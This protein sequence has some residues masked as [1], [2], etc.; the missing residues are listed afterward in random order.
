MAGQD[1]VTL[2]E[3]ASRLEVP[4]AGDN[5]NF[6]RDAVFEGSLELGGVSRS[7]WGTLIDSGIATAGGAST[8][9]D[10]GAD[11][12]STALVG[13]AL[14]ITGGTGAGQVRDIDSHTGTVITTT[15]AWTTQ[16]D[17][18]STYEIYGTGNQT[19]DQVIAASGAGDAAIKQNLL[20]A[21]LA[22][23]LSNADDLYDPDTNAIPVVGNSLCLTPDFAADTDWTKGA[24]WTIAAGVASA[25]AAVTAL[26]Q[27]V[28]VIKDQTYEITFTI[29]NYV[30]GGV[31]AYAEGAVLGV[32]RAANGTF[33]VMFVAAATGAVAFGVFGSTAATLDVDDVILT[34]VTPGR[35]AADTLAMDGWAKTATADIFREHSGASTKDGSFYALKMVSGAVDDIVSWPQTVNEAVHIAKFAGKTVT[36]GVWA[37][38]STANHARLQM[39]DGISDFFSSYHTGGGAYEWLEVTAP[40]ASAASAFS[41]RLRGDVNAATAYFSQPMLAFGSSIGEGNYVPPTNRWVTV[42]AT[43][44]RIVNANLLAADDKT[45]SLEV[46][47]NG[48]LPK[49]AKTLSVRLAGQNSAVANGQG[50]RIGRESASSN[51]LICNPVVNNMEQSVNGE[52]RVASDGTIYQLV[53]TAG[54]TLSNCVCDVHKVEI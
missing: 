38:T 47:S 8:L 20:P 29:S 44:I 39:N 33:S 1:V 31:K 16:P 36:F 28:S 41:A 3:V 40:I 34:V 13:S 43:S 12:G 26:E 45:L 17:A 9:T 49:G 15:A 14:R 46:E 22:E 35:V 2:D 25:A 4:Q 54:D 50:F 42:D 37:K 19:Q 30:G 51:S 21:N 32:E 10:S 24:N 23:V 48:M 53:S 18:T 11:W 52:I 7:Q 6:P 5:Y 27:N